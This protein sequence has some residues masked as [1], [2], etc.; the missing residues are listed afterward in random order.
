MPSQAPW[1]TWKGLLHPC[2]MLASAWVPAQQ[3]LFY[4]ATA[5]VAIIPRCW[6][7]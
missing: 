1:L 5:H 3:T 2:Q 6:H 4:H 7:G